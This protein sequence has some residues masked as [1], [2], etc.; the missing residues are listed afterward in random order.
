MK[1]NFLTENIQEKISLL[2]KTLPSHAPIP[3]L[4]SILIEATKEGLFLSATDLEFGITVQIPAKIE[5]EGG[6]LIPGKQFIEIINSL[7]K[8]KAT[9]TQ[10]KDQMLLLCMKMTKLFL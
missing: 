7:G 5:E 6:V 1:V 2:G 4:T 9:F 8:E 3:V 10:E